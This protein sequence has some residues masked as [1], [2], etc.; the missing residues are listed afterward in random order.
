MSGYKFESISVLPKPWAEC[1]RAEIENRDADVVNNNEQYCSIVRTG[2]G[3]SALV[4]GGEVDCILGE[5]PS[6]PDAPIP[7]IELKTTAE[8]PND[9]PREVQKFER[10]LLR[11]WAQSF[12]LGVPKIM[13]G[14]RTGDGFLTRI[15]ELETQRVP[16]LVSRGQG[17]WNGNICINMTA[18]FLEFLKATIM[19]TEGVWRIKRARNGNDIQVSKIE[20]SGTGN[21]VPQ[22]F[23]DHRDRVLAAEVAQKLGAT[24]SNKAA[25]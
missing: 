7:W 14:Y 9:H 8:P 12:L 25:D 6:N 23:K 5:K 20:P 17:T 19:A 24:A 1:T 16:G 4:L 15:Q 11:F 10:K 3:K 22:S 21:I 2:I 13:V 18:A